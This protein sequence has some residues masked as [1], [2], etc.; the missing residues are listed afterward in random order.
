MQEARQD[1]ANYYLYVVDN[2]ARANEDLMRVRVVHGPALKNMI[3]RT[4]PQVTYWPTFRAGEY[5][6][7]DQ[8]PSP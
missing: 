1:P 8:L 2:V 3:D 4:K 5:D 7:A 6:N